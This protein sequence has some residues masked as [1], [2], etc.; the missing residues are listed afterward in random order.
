MGENDIFRLIFFSL[1][2]AVLLVR[3]Y[4]GATM[5]RGGDS[6]WALDEAALQR[7]GWMIILARLMLFIYLLAAV[8]LFAW[9]PSWLAPACISLPDWA[10]WAGAGLGL[11]GLILL[12]WVHASLGRGWSTNLTL[13]DDHHLVTV[14]PYRWVR[15][16]MYTALF[17][18]FIGL[19]LLSANWLIVLVAVG[20]LALLVGRVGKEEDMLLSHFG[21]EYVSYM[22]HT[23]RFLPRLDRAAGDA[24]E[25]G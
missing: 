19:G 22:R 2:F 4:F 8:L 20:G 1:F 6:S 10:R 14:G 25:S 24:V 12:V 9:A 7:E 5:R 18:I 23:G 21:Q 13:R 15:H 3:A 17:A 11:A 16:P